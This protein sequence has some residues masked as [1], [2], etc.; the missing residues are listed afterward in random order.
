MFSGGDGSGSEAMASVQ[1]VSEALPHQPEGMEVIEMNN[2]YHYFP[3]GMF[4]DNFGKEGYEKRTEIMEA[5]DEMIAGE[6]KD[7]GFDDIVLRLNAVNHEIERHMNKTI[8]RYQDAVEFKAEIPKNEA[9]NRTELDNLMLEFREM[10][11]TLRPIFE[12]LLKRGFTAN[13]LAHGQ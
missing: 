10:N 7:Q 6:F 9:Q 13:Q 12:A 1:E 3:D 2:F 5:I 11:E 4:R 8:A